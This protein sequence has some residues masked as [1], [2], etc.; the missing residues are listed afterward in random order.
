MAIV[1]MNNKKNATLQPNAHL[2]MNGDVLMLAKFANYI[3]SFSLFAHIINTSVAA[4]ERT[5]NRPFLRDVENGR[6]IY[7]YEGGELC[8]CSCVRWSPLFGEVVKE[9]RANNG[10]ECDPKMA[11]YVSE[12]DE[13]I[14]SFFVFLSIIE[15]NAVAKVI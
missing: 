14:E 9:D 7:P 1:S 11:H 4:M 3:F 12:D 6:N 13:Y 10:P 15:R 8:L 2:V 5:M